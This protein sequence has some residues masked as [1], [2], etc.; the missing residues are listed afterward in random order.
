MS[1]CRCLTKNGLG[2]QCSRNARVTGFCKQHESCKNVIQKKQATQTRQV[3]QPPQRNQEREKQA[4]Q[5]RQV[6]QPPQRNQKREKPARGCVEQSQKKYQMR[7]SPPFPANE[8]C[9]QVMLGND[10]R[11]YVSKSYVIAGN[12]VCRWVPLK[13]DL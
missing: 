3:P 5:T 10:Q 4:T 1:Q 8:C 7:P 9:G 2:P 13:E 11:K 12:N 6:P